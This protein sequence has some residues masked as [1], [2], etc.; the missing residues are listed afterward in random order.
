MLR[1]CGLTRT[2]SVACIMICVRVAELHSCSWH[3][4]GGSVGTQTQSV[5][6]G[7]SWMKPGPSLTK[8]RS[9]FRKKKNV[10]TLRR[11]DETA[12][13]VPTPYPQSGLKHRFCPG[14]VCA[15]QPYAI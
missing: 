15:L 11:L 13:L 12:F 3:H 4:S 8:L 5:A 7:R 6:S 1:R 2:R 9:L 14:R 10:P